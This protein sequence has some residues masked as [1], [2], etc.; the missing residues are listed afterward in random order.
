M[1]KKLTAIIISAL[2]CL[3]IV[4]YSA[5][6]VSDANNQKSQL[7][8]ENKKLQ[9]EIDKNNESIN[10]KETEQNEL[11]SELEKINN[12][13]TTNQQQLFDLEKS[14]KDAKKKIETLNEDVDKNTDV[15]RQRIR[16][17]YMAGGATNLEIVL[18]A[19][20]FSDFLDK[21]ELVKNISRHDNE[22]INNIKSQLSGL[23]KEKKQL[24]TDLKE[25]EKQKKEL[26]NNQEK[27]ETLIKENSTE[28][29]ALYGKNQV[30]SDAL[31]ENN[32]EI[33]YLNAEVQKYYDSLNEQQSEASESN[34]NSENNSYSP[35]SD[36]RE[37]A[38]GGTGESVSG[39]GSHGYI[40]PVPGYYFLTSL[41]N[42]DRTTY[43]HGAIDIADSGING[44]P[45]VAA[46]D[47]VVA[48]GNNSCPHNWGKENSCGCGGGYGNY[49][50]ID[51]GNGYSTLYA[52]M[53]SLAVSIGQTVSK[54]D[55]IGY[56]GS[57]GHSTGAH[58]HF[59][60][61]LN[62]EKYNPMN[63]YPDIN[64]SY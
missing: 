38:Q 33:A 26:D 61:R 49:V 18:G 40:W 41:W 43:N 27:Y 64:I 32:N 3:Q 22:L 24:E 17:I 51:H 31:E 58:L 6:D 19:K 16:A 30:A 59:E 29:N 11:I 45:V 62:G 42:E 23:E 1:Y 54:G 52:H 2:L 10:T 35:P 34:N 7:E 46:S 37:L 44:A 53:S 9:S 21:L 57:T 25:Q 36:N 15:L 12:S 4:T 55:I 20:D 50:M 56:V 8:S 60:T 13:I 28:L 5:V 63:E 39:G 14:I 47:G 48:I